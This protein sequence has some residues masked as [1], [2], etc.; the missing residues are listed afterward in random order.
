[1]CGLC[2][3]DPGQG[4][5]N[6]D[7]SFFLEVPDGKYCIVVLWAAVGAGTVQDKITLTRE[8]REND[9]KGRICVARRSWR[10]NRRRNG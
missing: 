5:E 4:S 10:R 6:R 3:P 8:Q 2:M 7:P 1:M 9:N